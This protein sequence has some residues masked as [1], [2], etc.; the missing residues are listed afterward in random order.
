[1]SAMEIALKAAAKAGKENANLRRA[2]YGESW[3]EFQARLSANRVAAGNTTQ[4]AIIKQM[5]FAAKSMFAPKLVS[6][7][8]EEERAERAYEFRCENP[9]R[10]YERSDYEE[11]ST[12]RVING[13]AW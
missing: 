10:E 3:D 11:H 13:E 7:V 9:P 4:D 8:S 6:N 2:L 12:Y 5:E 1:M